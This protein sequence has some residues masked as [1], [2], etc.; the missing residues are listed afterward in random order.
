MALGAPIPQEDLAES[1]KD[2]D[3][4]SATLLYGLSD[5]RRSDPFTYG[6]MQRTTALVFQVQAGLG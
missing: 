2:K 5:P 3:E 1:F 4:G 6:F